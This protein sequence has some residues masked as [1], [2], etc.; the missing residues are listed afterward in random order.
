LYK[1]H[2]F[3]LGCHYAGRRE[4]PAQFAVQKVRNGSQA[5]LS[6]YRIPRMYLIGSVDHRQ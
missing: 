1:Y 3:I 6:L 2:I 4:E 5:P